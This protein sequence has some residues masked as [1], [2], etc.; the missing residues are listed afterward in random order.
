MRK[1]SLQ[2]SNAMRNHPTGHLVALLDFYN[3]ES[4]KKFTVV[5]GSSYYHNETMEMLVH[6]SQVPEVKIPFILK[7]KLYTFKDRPTVTYEVV[8]RWFILLWKMSVCI[9]SGN[10]FLI[11]LFNIEISDEK[12][13]YPRFCK[14]IFINNRI[15]R[16]KSHQKNAC[17]FP[18]S[19][20]NKASF[21]IFI[22][23]HMM[24]FLVFLFF[25]V[26]LCSCLCM[27]AIWRVTKLKVSHK[28]IYSNLSW[29]IRA[30]CACRKEGLCRKRHVW[31]RRGI[32]DL[33]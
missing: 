32:E 24:R 28:R 15:A 12:L 29:P 23:G 30:D 1:C 11:I 14:E 2:I 3:Q 16:S 33:Q 8:T 20:T 4:L 21:S 19:T 31:E 22:W 26:C 6:N 18:W 13:H 5:P 10:F 7:D 27:Y 25:S 17:P 9:L